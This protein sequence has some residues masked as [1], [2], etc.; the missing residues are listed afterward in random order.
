MDEGQEQEEQRAQLV[1][2]LR[3]FATTQ[4]EMGRMFARTR[5]MHT[6]DAAAV[7]EILTAEDRALPLT[8]ARLAERIGL[9]TGATSTLLNRLEAAGHVQRTRE[10]SDRRVV[11]LHSTPAIHQA[12]DDFFAPLADQLHTALSHYSMDEL[13]LAGDIVNRL[14]ATMSAYLIDGAT[15]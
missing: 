10:H 2:D 14:Q 6:T 1:Q 7:V 4:T 9:S 8:P 11:T 13:R 3:A 15:F 12:A 5:H